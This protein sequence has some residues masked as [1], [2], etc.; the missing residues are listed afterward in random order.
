MADTKQSGQWKDT[1]QDYKLWIKLLK[2]ELKIL[3]IPI[4][5]KYIELQT[6]EEESTSRSNTDRN[7][8][9]QN[10]LSNSFPDTIEYIRR[11]KSFVKT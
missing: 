8:E 2:C 9:N 11:E 7:V 6:K 3:L 1:F 5:E 4:F 10:F